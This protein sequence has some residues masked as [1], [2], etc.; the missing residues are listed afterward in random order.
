MK[1]VIQS[2]FMNLHIKMVSLKNHAKTTRLLTQTT[3]IALKSNNVWIVP[4]GMKDVKPFKD[5]TINGRYLNTEV[6]QELLK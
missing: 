6:S 5:H 2:E 3:L 1:V 4:D